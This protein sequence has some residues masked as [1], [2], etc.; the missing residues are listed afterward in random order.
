MVSSMKYIEKVILENFQSHKHSVL[1]FNNQ[2]NVIVGPSDSG[3]TAILRGIRWVL[4]NEPSGDYFIREGENYCAV[5][6]VF[7]DGTRV[8]RYRSRS[9]NI[10]YL[11]N[12]DNDETKFEGF[13]T[14]VPEEIINATGIKKI[15]LD[16]DLSKPINL[17]DQLEGAFL[18]SERASARASSIGRLVGV[19]IIDDT[20]RDTLKDVRNLSSKKKIIEDN[21]SN[22]KDELSQYEYLDELR[23]K[24]NR[25]SI[26]RDKIYEKN[27]LVVTY[28]GLNEKLKQLYNNKDI[29][30]YYL[31]KLSN[32]NILSDVQNNIISKIS[33]YNYLLTKKNQLHKL[34]ED[35]EYNLN[36]LSS[37]KELTSLE[38]KANNIKDFYSL[39]T[40]LLKYKSALDKINKEATLCNF[41]S[42]KLEGISNVEKNLNNMLISIEKLKK[43]NDIKDKEYSLRKSLAIGEKYVERFNKVDEVKVIKE[44]LEININLLNKLRT[45]FNS[46]I[47]IKDEI[48][49]I[50]TL[51]EEHKINI[52]LKVEEYKELLLKLEV[53]PLCFSNIDNNKIAHIISHYNQEV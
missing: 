28:K 44:K 34:S 22:L 51:L 33:L 45:I 48:T 17:S 23:D 16:S 10:Y 37:L 2:L 47:S 25:I 15:L 19:N 6:I 52:D 40:Q 49:N 8:K 24:I 43:L 11:Y 38:N 42:N 4:Y 32:I 20:L 36:I 21:I 13:G 9:K 29:T 35:K 50:R 27:N 7:S 14:S 53:C 18:L 26:I 3:K 1:E 5:T 46:Y 39:N 30:N 12:S 31:Q 41:I